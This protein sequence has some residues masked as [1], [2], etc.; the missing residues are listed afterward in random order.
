MNADL[1]E[2]TRPQD[3]MLKQRLKGIQARA[4]ATR[5]KRILRRIKS[6][7]LLADLLPEKPAPGYSYHVISHGDV[8]SLS[9][10]GHCIK[11]QDFDHVLISTWC[12]AIADVDQLFAWLDSGRI[13]SIDFCCGEIFPGSYPDECDKIDRAIA[14]GKPITLT[15]ARNHSK[16]MLMSNEADS[17]YLVTESSANVN[18][19]PRIEQTVLTHDRDLLEFYK[20]F[21]SGLIS[22]HKN[23][24]LE[25]KA[26]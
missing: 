13:K 4:I 18:T 21:F 11:A 10:L 15:I 5:N 24:Y 26:A 2:I 14:A 17:V 8:D 7:E 20:E 1:F 3:G 19:N 25:R 6:E 9:Y 23:P 22:V 16:V 12:I